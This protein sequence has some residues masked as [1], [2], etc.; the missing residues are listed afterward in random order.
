MAKKAN[1]S[2]SAEANISARDAGAAEVVVVVVPVV[3][4]VEVVYVL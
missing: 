4:S 1:K 2:P 3:G